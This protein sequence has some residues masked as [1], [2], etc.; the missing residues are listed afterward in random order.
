MHDLQYEYHKFYKTCKRCGTNLDFGEDCE[1]CKKEMSHHTDDN[2]YKTV[3]RYGEENPYWFGH[4][5]KFVCLSDCDKNHVVG[6]NPVIYNPLLSRNFNKYVLSS[7]LNK[8]YGIQLPETELDD[9][10]KYD[11]NQ[12]NE[13][14]N[15]FKKIL[16]E[17]NKYI[18]QNNT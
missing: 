14:I 3:S 2:N 12:L 9:L 8:Y 5:N 7:E 11:K 6:L 1:D 13:F 15:H 18:K 4:I 10:T 17:K 16:N